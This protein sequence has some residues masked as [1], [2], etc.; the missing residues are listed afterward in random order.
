MLKNHIIYII[1]GAKVAKGKKTSIKE[2]KRLDNNE[3]TINGKEYIITE[4]T[5]D[6]ESAITMKISSNGN[7]ILRFED[8][9][10]KAR[11]DVKKNFNIVKYSFVDKDAASKFKK[12]HDQ[13]F[14]TKDD[15][16]EVIGNANCHKDAMEMIYKFTDKKSD[17]YDSK[18]GNMNFYLFEEIKD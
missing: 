18:S 6:I 4:D 5:K 3:I 15:L 8:A 1:K 14:L 16:K 17:S 7:R 2:I 13:N 11:I 9:N 10:K 12:G